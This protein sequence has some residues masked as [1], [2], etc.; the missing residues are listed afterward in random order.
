M[1]K[2]VYQKL[3]KHLASMGMG[4]PEKEELIEILKENFTSVEAEVALAI[5]AKVIPFEPVAVDEIG[6]PAQLSREELEQVLSN[7]AQRGLLFSQKLK[8]GRIGYALQQFGYGFPQTFFWRGVHTPNAKKMAEL[9]IKYSRKEEI[10]EVYGKTETKAFRYVP[11]TLSLE[12]ESHAVFPFEMMEEVIRRVKVIA[13]VHCPCRATA[14]LI[15][16]KKCDHPLEN[17]IKYDEL[18]EYLIEKGIGREITK[19]EA[20]AV[21]RRSEEA[22]LVHLVDNSREGIK[23]TCNCCGCCCWSVGTIRRKK[24]PRDVLMA[25][26]FI[27]ETDEERCTGCGQCVEICPVE[28]IKMEGDFPVIDRDWCIGCGVCAVPCP[29]SAVKLVRKSN[30][31]PPKDFKELHREIL[32]QRKPTAS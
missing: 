28:V 17:C 26:Y 16:K 9:V 23:H 13:L 11:A 18:A 29:A 2:D 25:T 8:D 32:R 1:S 15:G 6:P 10:E 4:Y 14:Q 7:L 5:P 19:Q 21:V 30:A 20:L 24:I 22:G 3:A 27:R 31:I 12:P